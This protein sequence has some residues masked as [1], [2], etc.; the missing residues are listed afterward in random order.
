MIPARSQCISNS[1]SNSRISGSDSDSD[2]DSNNSNT[3]TGSNV[4]N[5]QHTVD[6]YNLHVNRWNSILLFTL[7][8]KRFRIERDAFKICT[9]LRRDGG[10]GS[11]IQFSDTLTIPMQFREPCMKCM[12]SAWMY[13]DDDNIDGTDFSNFRC[14]SYRL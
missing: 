10:Y 2:R 9:E 11:S 8:I 7:N 1:N 5:K 13:M 14:Y 3:G 6:R 4:E 12:K